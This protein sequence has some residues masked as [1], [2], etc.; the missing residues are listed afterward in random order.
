ML[1]RSL[2]FL[3][4]LAR[5][6]QPGPP[7]LTLVVTTSALRPWLAHGRQFALLDETRW[8]PLGGRAEVTASAL[9]LAQELLLA[10]PDAG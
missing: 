9:P 6:P 10:P 3:A 2:D 7:P 5:S 1:F 8:V 4:T